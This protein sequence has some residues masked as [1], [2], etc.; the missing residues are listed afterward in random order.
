[1]TKAALSQKDDAA[2]ELL[3]PRLADE[4]AEYN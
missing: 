2:F 4:H 1:M 3:L